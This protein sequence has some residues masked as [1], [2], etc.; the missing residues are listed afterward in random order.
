M[1]PFHG[2]SSK[3]RGD[4]FQGRVESACADYPGFLV[5]VRLVLATQLHP[6]A[7]ECASELAF[8]AEPLGHLLGIPMPRLNVVTLNFAF[9]FFFFGGGLLHYME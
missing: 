8:A 7:S 4:C 3:D 1:G 9:E 2:A 5:R 6:D